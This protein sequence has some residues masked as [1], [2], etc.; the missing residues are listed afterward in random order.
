MARTSE[1]IPTAQL[2][3]AVRSFWQHRSRGP[4]A[5]ELATMLG[6]TTGRV[7]DA[8]AIARHKGLVTGKGR[9][10]KVVEVARDEASELLRE[11]AMR[12]SRNEDGGGSVILPRDV[13]ERL[14][15]WGR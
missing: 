8:I 10:L 12:V 14:Q 6:R 9:A 3:V 7:A 13:C 1:P 11:I 4:V 2:L 5:N 15:K